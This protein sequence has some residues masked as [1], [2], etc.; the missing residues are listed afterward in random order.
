MNKF[1]TGNVIRVRPDFEL[2]IVTSVNSDTISTIFFNHSNSSA[3][4]KLK[5]YTKDELCWDCDINDGGTSDVECETCKGTGTYTKTIE[6]AENAEIIASTV[7]E[8]IMKA[9]TKNFNF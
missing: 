2:E 4:R 6:G 9:L 7:K 8:F 3:T 1:K 5:T